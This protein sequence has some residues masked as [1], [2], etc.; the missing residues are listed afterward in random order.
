MLLAAE[1]GILVVKVMLQQ[2]GKETKSN[3]V[4]VK[5]KKS[6]LRY[7]SAETQYGILSVI[8]RYNKKKKLK[9]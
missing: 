8:S 3:T 5:I 4:K 7:Q 6:T 1:N 2:I 9:C